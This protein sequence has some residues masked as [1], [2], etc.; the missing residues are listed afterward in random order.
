VYGTRCTE[1]SIAHDGIV[2][3]YKRHLQ[4]CVEEGAHLCKNN[5]M[6]W[7]AGGE[8]G[9][10]VVGDVAIHQDTNGHVAM[11]GELVTW[12]LGRG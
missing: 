2:N 9:S 7:G 10:E 4:C 11:V 1:V 5:I 8:V 3:A 12:V 6:C